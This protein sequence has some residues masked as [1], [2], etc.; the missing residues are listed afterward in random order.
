MLIVEKEKSEKTKNQKDCK[1]S[2]KFVI[3]IKARAR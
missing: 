1:S 3:N 2:Y